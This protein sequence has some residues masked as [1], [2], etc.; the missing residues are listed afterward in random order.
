MLVCYEYTGE[1]AGDGSGVDPSIDDRSHGIGYV[2]IEKEL[3]SYFFFGEGDGDYLGEG[4]GASPG[5]GHG[6]RFGDGYDVSPATRAQDVEI[7]I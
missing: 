3:W 5:S 1:G 4:V 7:L 2:E 6:T